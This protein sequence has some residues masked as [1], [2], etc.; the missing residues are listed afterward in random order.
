M[1][2]R[3]MGLSRQRFTREFKIAAVRRLQQG[4]TVAVVARALEV[5]PGLLHRWREEY[6]QGP[7]KAFPGSGR[8]GIE[9]DRVAQLERKIGQQALEIDFLKGCLQ[10][11]EE[12]RPLQA[13]QPQP[14][15]TRKS[16]N[17]E[18]EGSR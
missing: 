10:S 13:R 5:N 16:K 3:R 15:S 8:R 18:G 9:P 12:Q 14:P 4:E 17:G 11:I 1:E 7:K 6:Q 2:D